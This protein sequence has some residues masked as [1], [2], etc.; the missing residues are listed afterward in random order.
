MHQ[1]MS[2]LRELFSYNELL[3][4]ITLR[5]I[6]IRYKQSVLGAMWAIIQPLSM[7]LIFTVVFSM[8]AKIPSDG[9]PY[10]IF[11]YVALLPWTFFASSL[12]FA[13]P[14]ISNNAN[15]VTK[16]Y[17]P[18]EIFPIASVLA[19]GVDLVIA[20]AIF[21]MMMVF[22]RVPLTWYTLYVV[23]LVLLQATL[24][25]GVSFWASAV[26][27]RYRD[28]KYALP[29]VL[30]LWMYATPIVYPLSVVPQQYR[31]LYVLNPMAGIIDAYRRAVLLGSPPES[32]SVGVSALLAVIVFALAYTYFKRQ[33]ATFADVV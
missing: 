7:M 2:H 10:P 12:S 18:R 4:N 5:E 28:I 3:Y 25:L 20:S 17:F 29:F 26:N 14:S 32:T 21:A 8:F 23:P 33:E 9:I 19:A 30:Q 24:A 22:Y 11:S 27:V 16:V 31:L 6:K 15:L 13:I 1:L